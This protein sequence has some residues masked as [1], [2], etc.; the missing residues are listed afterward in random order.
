M[1]KIIPYYRD[2]LGIDLENLEHPISKLVDIALRVSGLEQIVVKQR[3][4][5]IGLALMEIK[6]YDINLY[7]FY[8]KKIVNNA[9]L[10]VNG[11]FFEVIQCSNLIKTAQ[12]EKISFKF[13][14]H[15]LDEPDFFLDDCGFELTIIRFTEESNKRNADQKLLKKFREKNKKKYAN[16]DTLLLIEISQVVH[17]ANQ[18]EFKPQIGFKNLLKIISAESRFG[19]VLCYIE[20]IVVVPGTIHFKGT[21]HPAYGN[22]Y[23]QKLRD[24][25]QRITKGK[26]NEFPHIPYVSP[27]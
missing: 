8:L 3:L 12:E 22:E 21:V 7:E 5:M 27:F 10:S 17:Y 15:S 2:W 26:R 25:I 4:R 13:G 24:V 19:I 11:F 18:P 1:D 23:S 6:D 14:D 16:K 20:N 9:D